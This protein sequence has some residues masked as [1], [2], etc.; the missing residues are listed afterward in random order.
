MAALHTINRNITEVLTLYAKEKVVPMACE[1]QM[2]K[3]RTEVTIAGEMIAALRVA[4][5]VRIISFGF[6]ESTKF[7]LGLLSTNTQIEPHDALGT[8]VDVVMRGVTLTAGGTAEAISKWTSRRSSSPTLAASSHSGRRST[9]GC[10]AR[11]A[12][13]RRTCPRLITSA[14]TA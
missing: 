1:R 8:S 11:A 9:S 6:D 4:L 3:L 5:C 14:Y 13:R 12:G 10:S 7:G 2:R